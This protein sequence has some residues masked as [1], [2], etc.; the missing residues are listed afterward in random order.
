MPARLSARAVKPKHAAARPSQ[1]VGAA[2]AGDG[3]LGAEPVFRRL[4][5]QRQRADDDGLEL[6][7]LAV[8]RDIDALASFF[9]LLRAAVEGEALHVDEDTCDL[10]AVATAG[11]HAHPTVLVLDADA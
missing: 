4:V 9:V 3:R 8:I 6:R 10:Q 7:G 1:D 5:E 2:G 11:M